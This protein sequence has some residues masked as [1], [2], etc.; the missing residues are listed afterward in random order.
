MNYIEKC[1]FVENPDSLH[2][3]QAAFA[4]ALE[5]LGGPAI[6]MAE[7]ESHTGFVDGVETWPYGMINAFASFGFEVRHIDGLSATDL[8]SDPVSTLRASGLDDETLDYFLRITDFA[9][10]KQ[11][12]TS[13][14]QSGRVVFETRAPLIDDVQRGLDEGWLPI[15]SLDASVLNRRPRDG[16]EGHVV[17]A[18]GWDQGELVVSDPG[19]PPNPILRVPAELVASAMQSPTADSGTVTLV[20]GKVE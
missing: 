18:L 8:T 3:T 16:F 2:C 19:P 9:K 7:A 4:M 14:I 12:V 10:E 17:L 6:S 1:H 13:A 5:A 15:V 11:Y 20:R